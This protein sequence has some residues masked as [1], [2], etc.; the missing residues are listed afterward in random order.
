MRARHRGDRC[1]PFLQGRAALGLVALLLLGSCGVTTAQG[2][3]QGLAAGFANP[4]AWARP[5]A[6]WFWMNGNI[7]REGITHDLES[8]QR[9]GIGGVTIFEV[10]TTVPPGPVA[11]GSPA[12]HGM[13]QFAV[14]EAARLGLQIDMNNDAGWCGSGGPWIT[15]SLSEQQLV[16]SETIVPGGSH[17]DGVLPQP[18]A[19]RGYYAD[20]AVVAFPTPLDDDVNVADLKP[21]MTASAPV[22]DADLQ[23]LSEGKLV[24]IVLPTPTPEQP[25]YIQY[26]FAQPFTARTLSMIVKTYP[27]WSIFEGELQSSDDGIHFKTIQPIKGQV[28]GVSLGFTGVTARFFRVAVTQTDSNLPPPFAISQIDLSSHNRIDDLVHKTFVKRGEITPQAH[29]LDVPKELTV[30]PAKIIDLTAQMQ[31][32][33]HLAWDAPPGTKWTVLRMG[34]TSRGEENHPAPAGGL[35]LECDKLNPDATDVQFAGLMG[36]I[37]DEIGPLAGKTLVA[38]HVDSWETG[39]QNWTGKFRQ[40]FLARRGYDLLPYLPAL[41]GRVVNN[42]ET[43]ERFLWDFRQTIAE[44]LNDHYAQRLA[45][46]AHQHGLQF[47]NEAYGN[48]PT[49]DLSYGARADEPM[50]EFWWTANPHPKAFHGNIEQTSTAHVYGKPIVG[51]EAFTADRDDKFLAYP[52]NIKIL[53]DWAFSMGMNRLN[54]SESCLQPFPQAQP[55][56]TLSSYG[57]HYLT[58]QTWWDT[59]IPWHQYVTRVQYLLQQGLFVADLCYLQPERAP[60]AFHLPAPTSYMPV[61]PGYNFDGAPAEAVLTRFSVKDGKLVLPDGM[62]YRVLVLP[63]VPTMTPAL[64]KKIKQLV[65]DGATVIGPRPQK[66]P[67]LNDY[68]Q[69]D[70]EIQSLGADLWGNCDGQTVKEHAYGKGKVIWG[71]A[72]EDVLAQMQVPPDFSYQDAAGSQPFFIHHTIG[73]TDAYFVANAKNEPISGRATFRVTGKRAEF[74]WP[75]TGQIEPVA[76]YAD[77]SGVIEMPIHLEAA[78]SVFVVFRPEAAPVDPIVS[79]TLNGGKAATD[80]HLDASGQLHLLTQKAGSYVFTTAGG[81]TRS[82]TAGEP[83]APAALTG[84]WNLKFPPAWGAPDHVTLDSLAS[85][86]ENADPG[87]KYFSGTATYQ[88]TFQVPGEMLGPGKRLLL[89]LGRV[90]VIARVKLN[91]QDLGFLWKA[92]FVVDVTSAVRT[93]DNALEIEVTN[94]WPNRMIGDAQ[95]PK[96]TDRFGPENPTHIGLAKAWPDWLLQGKPSPTGRYTF[97]FGEYYHGNDP[98]LPSGLIGPVMLRPRLDL[99]VP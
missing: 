16:W 33:G 3:D 99:I 52:A 53:G 32:D 93:G 61:R 31:P 56:M 73:D 74:W 59:T 11:F 17:Y 7:T 72:P 75:E 20:T 92:P 58:T 15:P 46:L 19:V 60:Q 69:C 9:V 95:L 35:G 40:E 85:W 47:S 6:Y 68:P 2:T 50:C 87:V 97:A 8:M 28:T 51:A 1:V 84:S 22:P 90:Q 42:L 48:C 82:V 63:D 37:I 80:L 27:D 21:K 81:K 49:D 54:M 24:K 96:D 70:A 62:S 67:S 86:S 94:L 44:M 36:K 98:L 55:G 79:S 29:Y 12:W 57:M 18:R 23:K 5:W 10:N 13:F 78:Q 88:K 26:E 45:D 34:H 14:S 76:A 65:F 38:T 43:S 30:D 91:G 77:K 71:T 4:P 64:L 41:T 83:P 25:Q 89:D 39:S 66:S